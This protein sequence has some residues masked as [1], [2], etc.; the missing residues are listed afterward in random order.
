MSGNVWEW[1]STRYSD[2]AY[3]RLAELADSDGIVRNPE[4]LTEGA[5][6]V[7]RGGSA[8]FSESYFS[9]FMRTTQRW[10]DNIYENDYLG[11]RCALP[12]R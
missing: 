6:H 5:I 8:S 9:V 10:G 12:G 4:D 1:T 3:S 7:K 2:D 11:F